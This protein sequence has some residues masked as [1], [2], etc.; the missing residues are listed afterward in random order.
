MDTSSKI[1]IIG[2]M[3]AFAPL[4][5]AADAPPLADSDLIPIV[6][7]EPRIPT[8]ALIKLISG[9]VRVVGTIGTDG[10]VTEVHVVES[11]PPGVFDDAA[12]RA[13]RQWKWKPRIVD[14]VAVERPLDQRVVF[15]V[16]GGNSANLLPGVGLVSE[17]LRRLATDKPAEA[18]ALYLALRGTCPDAYAHADDALNSALAKRVPPLP[19]EAP[20][21]DSWQDIAGPVVAA[22]QCLFSSWEQLHD[23]NAFELAARYYALVGRTAPPTPSADQFRAFAA[24]LQGPTVPQAKDAK[25]QRL[26]RVFLYDQTFVAFKAAADLRAAQSPPAGALAPATDDAVKRAHEAAGAQHVHQARSIIEKALKTTAAPHD[27]AMLLNS[28]ATV[29]VAGG[30][31]EDGISTLDQALA[32]DAPPSVVHMVLLAKTRVCGRA[33]DPTCFDGAL[34]RLTTELGVADTLKF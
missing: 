33:P 23:P 15:N 30:D 16:L 13:V 25:R 22:S 19:A 26:V 34:S 2:G 3:L 21:G 18:K 9:S 10:S 20:P 11:H 6:R 8:M 4:A 27:R 12:L 24:Q 14:G 28:L 7:V 1:L 5:S 17:P 31:L 29:Q 32:L